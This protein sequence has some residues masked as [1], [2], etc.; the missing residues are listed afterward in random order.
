[1]NDR[2]EHPQVRTCVEPERT[3]LILIDVIND[4][5]VD[6]ESER[7][8]RDA[9]D[10]AHRIKALKSQAK[11]ACIPAIYANDTFQFVNMHCY[12]KGLTGAYYLRLF[13][14]VLVNTRNI[15]V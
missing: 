6:G 7:F 8:A 10:A 14:S 11:A 5:Q 4:M 15:H 12:G 9:L 2:A 3:A 1:M 13:I